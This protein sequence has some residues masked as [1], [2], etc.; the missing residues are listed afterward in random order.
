[1]LQWAGKHSTQREVRVKANASWLPGGGRGASCSARSQGVGSG[2]AAGPDWRLI[3][4]PPAM[5]LVPSGSS[6][7]GRT[8]QGKVGKTMRVLKTTAAR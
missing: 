2:C 1:M 8:G 6:G 5:K 7:Q 3:H 4:Q